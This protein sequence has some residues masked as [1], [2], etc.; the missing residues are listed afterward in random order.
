MGRSAC[1]PALRVGVTWGALHLQTLGF[2]RPGGLGAVP[3]GSPERDGHRGWKAHDTHAP[4]GSQEASGQGKPPGGGSVVLPLTPGFQHAEPRL[5][6]KATLPNCGSRGEV[7]PGRRG[8]GPL[9]VLCPFP[10]D[11]TTQ[12]V[13]GFDPLPPLDTIYSYVRPERYLPPCPW[14]A[15]LRSVPGWEGLAA[16]DS[17]ARSSDPGLRV[18]GVPVSFCELRFST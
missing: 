17:E 15:A 13:L 11:V 9:S 1:S 12:S 14:L 18:S 8:S 2:P 5:A 6:D 16:L 4:P 3:L 7:G 10:K